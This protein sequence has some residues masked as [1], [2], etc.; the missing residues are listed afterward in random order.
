ML[1]YSIDSHSPEHH[2]HHVRVRFDGIAW[3]D[4]DLFLQSTHNFIDYSV[5]E[6]DD[7]KYKDLQRTIP[8]LLPF[9]SA[10]ISPLAE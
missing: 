2:L 6:S 10:V 8:Q 7:I 3:A 4:L 1:R 5:S 9:F